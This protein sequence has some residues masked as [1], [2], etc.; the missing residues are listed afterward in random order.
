ME[1]PFS[2]ATVTTY[3]HATEDEQRVLTALKI[4]LPEG[5]EI[6]RSKLKGHHGNP[7]VG[8]EARIERRKI[9]RE[10]WQRVVA[11]LRAGESKPLRNIVR[12][13]IDETRHLYLRF[14]KQ[15]AYV[16]E[17]A[18]TGSGDAV[19]LRLKVAAFPAKREIAIGLVE[20]FIGSGVEDEAEA[21]VHS[22]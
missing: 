12:K 17:L 4:L 3:A 15:L 20:K 14:D 10:L 9:L 22:V 2:S 1:F 18:L 13:R 19:H 21:K 5:V 8:F 7:I 11:K 16:G 6:R